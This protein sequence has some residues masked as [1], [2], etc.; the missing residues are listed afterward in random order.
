MTTDK[1]TTTVESITHNRLKT[2]VLPPESGVITTALTYEQ[3]H[4]Q[5]LDELA[6]ETEPHTQPITNVAEYEERKKFLRKLVG[7]RTSID[8]ARKAILE[9]FKQLTDQI[10][11]YLGT[12]QQS[13]LQMRV[14]ELEAKVQARIKEWD[15]KE[16]AERLRKEQ[17]REALVTERKNAVLELS[18]IVGDGFYEL[19]GLKVYHADIATMSPDAWSGM[20]SAM[21]ERRQRLDEAEAARQ[22]AMRQEQEKLQR[23]QMQVVQE[24][25]AVRSEW[26]LD[27]GAER[28]V[29]NETAHWRLALG[30]ETMQ[31]SEA[32]LGQ[33]E[34][35][36]WTKL[37]ASITTEQ[38]R[39]NEL[40]VSRD[41]LAMMP[42]G[43]VEYPDGAIGHGA[44]TKMLKELVEMHQQG[45]LAPW[46]EQLKVVI[47][48]WKVEE[49][50]KKQLLE[51]DEKEWHE[52]CHRMVE[53][54]VRV[55]KEQCTLGGITYA[56]RELYNSND[57]VF[58]EKLLAFTKAAEQLKREKEEARLK[59]Q[60]D[61]EH[62]KELIYRIREVA[63]HTGTLK[64]YMQSPLGTTGLTSAEKGLM[65]LVDMLTKT[66]KDIE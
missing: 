12:G 57:E 7:K 28:R 36:E 49:E 37:R 26:L 54:G 8:K 63:N 16:E 22:E 11:T 48:D 56:T 5:A 40:K 53:I 10:N 45:T 14:A 44:H 25:I 35:E 24:R 66:I 18:P 6:K 21:Q 23:E 31:V 38:A 2:D 32:T 55:E 62:L 58:N 50:R 17:E 52:R 15:D 1:D 20:L 33:M 46:I 51:A 47:N 19:A 59:E 64:K 27:R 4:Q 61:V 29:D 13:G 43:V 60:N 3:Q 42:A 34:H 65:Q 30:G 41:V 9:P 39:I